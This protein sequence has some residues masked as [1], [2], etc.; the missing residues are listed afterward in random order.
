M[1]RS[2]WTTWA[3]ASVLLCLTTANAQA[4]EGFWLFS[5][6]PTDAVREA[7]GFD[8]TPEWLEH[9]QKS[10][11]AFRSGSGAFVSANGLVV[12]NYHVAR[13]LLDQLDSDHAHHMQ[14]GFCARTQREE[15]PITGLELFVLWY[16]ED[17]TDKVNATVRPDMTRYEAMR[18]RYRAIDNIY[19]PVPHLWSHVVP[20]DHGTRYLLYGVRHFNDIRL[21]MV[22]GEDAAMFGGDVDNFSYPRH[23]LDVA[24][25]RVYAYGQPHR[26][27]HFLQWSDNAVKDGALLF[28]AG[29]PSSTNRHTAVAEL[30]AL[31]DIDLPLRLRWLWRREVRTLSFASRH[32]A[33]PSAVTDFLNLWQNTRKRIA[34]QLESLHD[35]AI[36][37]QRRSEEQQLRAWVNA[38]ADRKSKW[39][40]AWDEIAAAQEAYPT[41]AARHLHLELNAA[42]AW[43]DLFRIAR[44][45]L[46]YAEESAKPDHQRM[47]EFRGAGL[48]NA[49]RMILTTQPASKAW[50]HEQLSAALAELAELLGGDHALVTKALHEQPPQMRATALLDTTRLWDSAYRRRLLDGGASAV[51]AS[52]DPMIELA[53]DIEPE[54]RAARTRWEREIEWLYTDAYA[55]I[56]QARRAA[57]TKLYAPDATNTLRLSYGQ[58]LGYEECGRAVPACTTMGQMF[59]KAQK[60]ENRAPYKLGQKWLASQSR[61]NP[62]TPLNFA[63]TLDSEAGSSGSPVVNTDGELVGVMFD[64]NKRTPI[65]KYVYS[66]TGARSIA[67]SGRAIIEALRTVYEAGPLAD[68]LEGN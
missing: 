24:F 61:I 31:R 26:A 15:L 25:F 50:E 49:R 33:P 66:D 40:S 60:H 5:E 48:D 30:E 46:R 7:Y 52:D 6:P 8:L 38:D 39:G 44:G 67:V 55:R 29:K 23:S 34:L 14:R 53:R 47:H 1:N 4:E 17:V 68:E 58:M 21:V 56:A 62:K 51:A 18:A 3:G 19:T 41:F 27:E 32:P 2:S 42:V 57:A 63:A 12:T 28:S 54:A 65:W 64:G 37:N 22:P 35:P 36:L 45:I 43:G 20:I 59:E 11:V 13:G 10:C 16:V 9:V